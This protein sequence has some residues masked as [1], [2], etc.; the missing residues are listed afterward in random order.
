LLVT[1]LE[2]QPSLPNN[3]HA[4]LRFRTPN[5]GIATGIPFRKVTVIRD[6]INAFN[7]AHAALTYSRR[8]NGAYLSDRSL[9]LGPEKVERWIAPPDFIERLAAPLYLDIEYRTDAATFLRDNPHTPVISTIPIDILAAL[10]NYPNADELHANRKIAN[11]RFLHISADIA[12]CDAYCTVYDCGSASH[13]LRGTITGSEA[14][15]ETNYNVEDLDDETDLNSNSWLIEGRKYEADNYARVN[16]FR[17]FGIDAFE[18]RN[19]RVSVQ[20]YAKI[21]PIE[22]F[23]RRR[24]ISWATNAKGVFSLGRYATWRP[25]LLM[26]DVLTDAEKIVS[27]V[28]DGDLYLVNKEM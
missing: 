7:R 17:L 6:T 20:Q 13:L 22:N 25:G 28:R 23:A 16:L 14:V 8:A 24:F 3:H 21:R 10:L 2:A 18:I 12:N 9:P 5:V 4:T 1:I 27:W 19:P 15:L 11:R 26:D